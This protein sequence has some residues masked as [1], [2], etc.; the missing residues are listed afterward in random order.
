[1]L[2]IERVTTRYGDLAAVDDL[3]L[4]VEAGELFCL[5]GPSGSGKSTVLRTVA[6]F[7]R[8]SAG[9]VVVGGTDVTAAPPYERD[10]AMVFQDW[11]LFPD[12]TVHENVAFGPRMAGVG[13]AERETRVAELLDLVEMSEY[14]NARPDQL[15]GGQRQ[16]V[17]LARSLAVDPDLLLLDEPLS[18][19]DRR[20]RETMGLELKRIHDRLDTTMLYVTHD[21]DEAFTLADR[22]GLMAD[23]RLVQV[24]EPAA[25]YGEPADRFVESFLGSTTFLDCRVRE[26]GAPPTLDTPMGVDLVAPIDGTDLAAGD[27]VEVSLRPERLSI[28]PGRATTDGSG[29]AERGVAGAGA[30]AVAVAGTAVERIH[31]GGTVLVR[32]RAGEAELAVERPATADATVTPGDDLRLRIEPDEARY[33]DASGVRLR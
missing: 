7:E 31:R 12:K 30:G 6:G 13:R 18:S 16:R 4:S 24:G 19:L 25:V 1:M 8:P 15:S 33:F 10:C 22:L 3:S 9:R 27:R 20:L 23:G 26:A 28:E 5:L 32:V 29:R 14:G 17:A 11:V 21:Q 2:D